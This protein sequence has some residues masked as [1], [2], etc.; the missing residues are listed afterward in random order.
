MRKI[1]L[2]KTKDPCG[3][4]TVLLS[5]DAIALPECQCV[6][7]T[8]CLAHY[9]KEELDNVRVEFFCPNHAN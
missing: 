5:S 7:H 2:S 4:C 9:Y 1:V 6:W 8:E 3:I